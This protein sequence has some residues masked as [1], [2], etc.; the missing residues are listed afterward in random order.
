MKSNKKTTDLQDPKT[1]L[2]ALWLFAMLTYTY[3]DVVT[4]MDPIKHGSLELT[5]GF[6]LGGSIF[7]MIP[8]SMV[9][10]SRILNYSS[11]RMTS[12]I[13]GSI[14]T[15]ALIMT[16]FVAV[17]TMYYA[18]FAVIEISTTGFITWYAWRNPAGIDGNITLTDG[19]LH[20]VKM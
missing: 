1:I 8:L 15:V 9:L 4:N 5:E 20:E 14:M 17:P 2:A 16:L 10:L 18:F 13:A 12:M 3:G 6:L 11:V 7:M 19:N